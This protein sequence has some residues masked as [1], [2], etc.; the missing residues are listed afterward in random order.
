M[1]V[2]HHAHTSRKKW[3]HY[4]WEFLMLFLAVFC[5]FLAEYQLEHKIE[6]EKGMQYIRSFYND[7]KTDTAEFTGLIDKYENKMNAL[8]KRKEC[9]DSLTGHTGSLNR[10]IVKLIRNCTSF[11]DFVNADQTLLQLKNAGGLRLLSQSDADSILDYDKDVRL[12]ITYE[13][14]GYQERQY[15]IREFL[16]SIRNYKSIELNNADPTIPALITNEPEKINHF[17]VMLSEYTAASNG[18]LLSL[19]KLKLKAAGLINYFK[20][21]YHFD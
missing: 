5:G 12:F 10:C 4:F 16:Y 2:H 9:F 20:G 14:T 15:N 18:H 17:F 7:L 13:T 19:K 8:S 3:T 1:E 21:K 11:P 6:K